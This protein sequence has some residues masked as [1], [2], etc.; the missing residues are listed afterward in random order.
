MWSDDAV[1]TF[2]RHGCYQVGAGVSGDRPYSH[3]HRAEGEWVG[4]DS[5]YVQME[6]AYQN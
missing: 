2:K 6:L 5:H 3:G 4:R 1:E